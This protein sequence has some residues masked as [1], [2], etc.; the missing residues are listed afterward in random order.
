MTINEFPI[1][2]I[3]RWTARIIGTAIL[4]LIIAITVGEGVPNPLNQPL[5]VSLLFAALLTMV[6]GLVLPG[7]GRPSVAWDSLASWSSDRGT[8]GLGCG[9]TMFPAIPSPPTILTR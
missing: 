9:S 1:L 3:A 2:A 7:N 8:T 5:D 6:V 4:L